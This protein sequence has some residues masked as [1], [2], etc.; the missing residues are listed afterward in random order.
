MKD[1]EGESG[2]RGA[3]E[4]GRV[5][6]RETGGT[7]EGAAIGLKELNDTEKNRVSSIAPSSSLPVPWSASL[8]VPQPFFPLG[9]W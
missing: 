2:V 1:G 4:T 3:W 7:G 5:V 8:V 6:D 9:A